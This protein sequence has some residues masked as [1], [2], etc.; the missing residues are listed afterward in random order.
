M[1]IILNLLL[2]IISCNI[3]FS[4]EIK[5]DGDD[6]TRSPYFFIK[7][8][9][10]AAEEFPL[11]GTSAEVQIFGVIADVTIHQ[12]YKNSG[13][14]PIEAIYVFPAS[15]RAAV[16]AM[17]MTVGG[18]ILEAEIQKKEEARRTYDNAIKQGKTASLLEQDRPNVF[19]M[20]VGN[21]LAGDTIKVDLK[22]TEMLIP[23]KGVYEFVYPTV[24]GPRY[25]SPNQEKI[26]SKTDYSN[27]PYQHEGEKPFYKFNINVNL[28]AGMTVDSLRSTTH[29]I[30][31]NYISPSKVKISLARDDEFA[32]NRDFILQYKLLGNRIETGLLLSDNEKEKF[33]L[34]MLQPPKRVK[35]EEIPS[36]EYIFVMDVSGSMTGFPIQV[37][38]RML[39][40][41]LLNTT[42]QDLFNVL[43]FSGASN[44][45]A[46]QS[47]PATNENIQK[48]MNIINKEKGGGG[49]E[50]LPALKRVYSMPKNDNYSR[51]IVIITDGFVTVEEEAIDLIKNNLDK[52]NVFAF[53]I[54][55]SVN[56]YLIEGMARAGMGEPFVLQRS[57]DAEQFAERFR[58]YIETPV[59]T[60]IQVKF[61]GFLA[62]DLQPIKIPDLFAER[63]ILLFGKWTGDPTGNI[64]VSGLA[65]REK[66]HTVVDVRKFGTPE[67]S[68]ALKYLW[69]RSR[70]AE[71]S[72]YANFS[73]RN[74]RKDEITDLG[75]KYNLL[76]NYTSFVAVDYIVRRQGD[77]MITV[78]Q[79][80]PMPEGV[81]DNAIG[82]EDGFVMFQ[83]MPINA[84]PRSVG[85][86]IGGAEA[87]PLIPGESLNI[88]SK[89]KTVVAR[90]G[91]T[92]LYGE[93]SKKSDTVNSNGFNAKTNLKPV[94]LPKLTDTPAKYDTIELNNNK[95][96]PEVAKK[97]GWEG[98]I[99]VMTFVDSTGKVTSM[100][101]KQTDNE[102]LNEA[103][104]TAIYK[105]KFSPAVVDGK[106]TTQWIEIP[107]IFTLDEASRKIKREWKTLPNGVKYLDVFK[108]FGDEATDTSTVVVYSRKYYGNGILFDDRFLNMIPEEIKINS[109][110]NLKEIIRA[111]IGIRP[112]GKRIIVVP[113]DIM[114]KYA[115]TNVK[116]PTNTGLVLEAEVLKVIK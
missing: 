71:L 18:R 35:P 11:L 104:K 23:E 95:V 36:R 99:V 106:L 30:T 24:V 77:S 83:K 108:G 100:D 17:R 107:V 65:G 93:S 22:Y 115:E 21:I 62:S 98:K 20:N 54:G 88:E 113:W 72:D 15:T 110:K 49:T 81:S 26:S 5:Q 111:F 52:A 87:N 33:F 29:N 12:V 112:G 59:M 13:K 45:L 9:S 78:K 116:I 1:K 43:L 57:E 8:D 53:G 28:F 48:A 96:Y 75:L 90:D 47:L 60:N 55:S 97:A 58:E 66:L 69:A 4:R 44:F 25:V 42:Q 76:T 2:L 89:G 114:K 92:S 84:S 70:I 51:I 102:F 63:P 7:G 14:K 82:I 3:A 46:E 91:V 105:T 50:L 41:L 109:E 85:Y 34:L 61:D 103:A 32:G 40:K 101:V 74:E 68:Q 31:Y 27:M 39:E 67:R 73:H 79:P 16:Y 80:L 86:S 64:I 10:S 38:K 37:S 94:P 6:K 56:R 19:T